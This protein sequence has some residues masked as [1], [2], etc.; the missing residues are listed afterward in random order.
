VKSASS[1]ISFSRTSACPIVSR[2]S[3]QVDQ[4]RKP[5]RNARRFF[6]ESRVIRRVPERLRPWIQASRSKMSKV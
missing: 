5:S 3:L 6:V 1:V 2:G 4:S